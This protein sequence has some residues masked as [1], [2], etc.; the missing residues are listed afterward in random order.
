MHEC[1]L[2]FLEFAPFPFKLIVQDPKGE[3]ISNANVDVWQA[4]SAGEYFL[5]T[6]RLR[7]QFKT[8]SK[9]EVEIL[10]VPPGKYGPA[11]LQ[12]AGHF[13]IIIKDPKGRF[14]DLTTQ[15]YVCQGNQST[16]MASDL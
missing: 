12:R 11:N 1:H 2:L 9:G 14:E 16:E 8:G 3:P 5:R 6:Y 4:T 13:H 10:S 15:V 7:G